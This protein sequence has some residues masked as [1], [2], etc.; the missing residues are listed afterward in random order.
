MRTQRAGLNPHEQWSEIIRSV[1][2]ALETST[3][4]TFEQLSASRMAGTSAVR[5]SIRDARNWRGGSR[6]PGRYPSAGEQGY[7]SCFLSV[8]SYLSIHSDSV[9]PTEK[10]RN[11]R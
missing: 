1:T 9:K 7:V 11:P 3:L 6:L 10:F 4:L 5:Q 2:S 8:D